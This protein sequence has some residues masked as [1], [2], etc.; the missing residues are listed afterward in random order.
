MHAFNDMFIQ[1]LLLLA[2]AIAVTSI[3][4]YFG[5]PYSI[6]LVI[7]GLFFG[8]FQFDLLQPIHEFV[9]HSSIFQVIIISLFLPVLLGEA[10]INL[11]FEHLKE[12]KKPILLLA[13]GGTFLS[14]L[15]VSAFSYYILNLSLAVSFVFGS[16]MAATDPISVISIFKSK[17]V[18]KKLSTIIEGESLFN[19]GIAVVLFQIS[20]V[21]L[22]TYIKMGWAGL[23]EGIFLFLKFAIGGL[24]IGCIMG[25]LFSHLTKL[26]DD[27]SLE[28]AYSILLFFGSYFIAEHFE[29][30]GV[31][32]VAVS[33]IIF[34]NYGSKIGMTPSTKMAIKSFWDVISLIASSI[35]FLMVGLEIG[36][37]DF[38]SK[39]GLIVLAIVMVIVA[40][41]LAVYL[42]VGWIKLPWNWLHLINWGGL[43]G[44]LSIA[45]ALSLPSSF[46]GR[47]IILVLTFSV[48]LF[49]LII[50]S[51]SIDPLIKL[52]K[53]IPP[54]KGL[55]HYDDVMTR[56]YRL[57]KALEKLST[58]RGDS[59]VDKPVYETLSRSYE[60]SLSKNQKELHALYDAY[61]GIQKEQMN[62]AKKQLLLAE[63]EA[64]DTLLKRDIVDSHIGEQQKKQI[65]ESLEKLDTE[66]GETD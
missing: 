39:W 19:D 25:Y 57:N 37:I 7:V 36:N 11:P 24:I 61:P 63:H 17:G 54:R 32:A 58:M 14:Y 20:S 15:L 48:V 12:N 29:V 27:Y 42:S 13:F 23:G 22:M 40:R 8:L 59:L 2:V 3:A 43:K 6:A 28:I 46:V 51:L 52:L 53:I 16:L 10:S 21:Y 47:D 5:K 41:S 66:K 55:K 62:D 64:V 44:S 38:S 9:T 26:F 35:I 56:N 65:I 33:G 50:Q 45:L 30:S 60:E 31:I 34:G 49:S 18:N 1:I 4:K